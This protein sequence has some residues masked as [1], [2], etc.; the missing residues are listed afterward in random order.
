MTQEAFATVAGYATADPMF[1]TTKDGAEVAHIRVACTPRRVDR[2]GAWQDGQT[3]YFSVT[4]WRKLAVAVKAS[5]RKG[6]PVLVRGRMRTRTWQTEERT[7][8]EVE[9]DADAMGHDLTRGWASFHREPR[10]PRDTEAGVNE[11]ELKRQSL[12]DETGPEEAYAASNP[13]DPDEGDSGAVAADADPRQPFAPTTTATA[14]DGSDILT[15]EAI[16]ELEE[17]EMTGIPVPA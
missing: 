8:S 5:I 2:N 6:D 17:D 16:A 12:G 3:S 11:G 14:A 7:V 4:C 1:R 15:E 10:V 13:E 9:I